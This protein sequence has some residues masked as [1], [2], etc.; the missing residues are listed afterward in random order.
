M[1]QQSGPLRK[2]PTMLIR[3]DHGEQEVWSVVRVPTVEQEDSQQLHR[4]LEA[5][6][7]RGDWAYQP[8]QGSFGKLQGS[9][10]GRG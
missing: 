1:L 6:E 10:E 2:L 3:Y 4:D 7:R 5:L 8:D 9:D